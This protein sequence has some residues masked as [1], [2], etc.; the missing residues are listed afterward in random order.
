MISGPTGSRKCEVRSGEQCSTNCGTVSQ[1]RSLFR[2]RRT[3][4]ACR[5]SGAASAA[6]HRLAD[7][8]VGGL[9]FI[10]RDVLARK[11][12]G[13]ELVRHHRP[14]ESI[15]ARARCTHAG[16]LGSHAVPSARMPCTRTGFPVAFDKERGL[17]R[18][19]AGVIAPVGAGAGTQMAR[20]LSGGMSSSRATPS[21][22]KCGFCEPVHTVQ[23]PSA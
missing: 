7:Q 17:D 1:P 18:R 15:A 8:A 5:R 20:T 9:R 22:T 16:P 19:V 4:P 6:A 12:F 3:R 14:L 23:L 13:D 10:G 21:R 2:S 11:A